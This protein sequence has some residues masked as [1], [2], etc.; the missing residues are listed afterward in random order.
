[1]NFKKLLQDYNKKRGAQKTL[2]TIIAL[3]CLRIVK[4]HCHDSKIEGISR[5]K[6]F[7]RM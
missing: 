6:G 5:I 7:W 3:N 1:M 4:K 2:F